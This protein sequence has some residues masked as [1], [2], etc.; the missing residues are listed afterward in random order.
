MI[1]KYIAPRLHTDKFI[2]SAAKQ[3]I[4]DSEITFHLGFMMRGFKDN[5]FDEDCVFNAD[6]TRF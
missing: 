5:I 4:M 1:A 3:G 2:L 6:E